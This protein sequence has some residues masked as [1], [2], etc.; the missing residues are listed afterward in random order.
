[1]QLVPLG[2]LQEPKG[3]HRPEPEALYVSGA[4][5]WHW[6]DPG[7]LKK[8]CAHGKHSEDPALLEV[9]AAHGRQ[10]VLLLRPW[11]GL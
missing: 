3:Q 2:A 9:P 10:E 1:M 4:Q 5:D 6:V 11:P 7:A 8:F